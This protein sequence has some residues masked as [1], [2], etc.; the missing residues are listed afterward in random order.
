[1]REEEAD[2]EWPFLSGSSVA[3]FFKNL[4]VSPPRLLPFDQ[5]F[6]CVAQICTHIGTFE[7]KNTAHIH[8][9]IRSFDRLTITNHRH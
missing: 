6:Q 4:F 5:V 3:L 7:K 2:D 8:S 1:M 9:F